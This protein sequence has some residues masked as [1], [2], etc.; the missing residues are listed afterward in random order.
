MSAF[1]CRL[2]NSEI[3]P[4]FDVDSECQNGTCF[5]RTSGSLP[6]I[7]M[8]VGLY[9]GESSILRS[10]KFIMIIIAYLLTYLFTY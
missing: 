6:L 9:S 7:D 8:L 2:E 10:V 5:P 1:L 3:F 4:L